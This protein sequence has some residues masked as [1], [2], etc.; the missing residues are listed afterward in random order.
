MEEAENESDA[1]DNGNE[2]NGDQEAVVRQMRKRIERRMRLRQTQ[3]SRQLL[4]LRMIVL[5]LRSW[6]WVR[7]LDSKEEKV[8]PERMPWLLHLPGHP[9]GHP[10]GPRSASQCIHL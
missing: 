7:T 1:L 5:I 4:L 9:P 2:G 8:D 10:P 6:R 3:A